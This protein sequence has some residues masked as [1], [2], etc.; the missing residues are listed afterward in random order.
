MN[1]THIYVGHVLGADTPFVG[2]GSGDPGGIGSVF[3][4][5]EVGLAALSKVTAGSLEAE[6]RGG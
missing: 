4:R 5:R 2:D 1:K 3:S 6:W